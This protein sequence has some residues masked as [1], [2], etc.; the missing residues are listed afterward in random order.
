[1]KD[2][3]GSECCSEDCEGTEFECCCFLCDKEEK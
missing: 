2:S 3:I 1:M